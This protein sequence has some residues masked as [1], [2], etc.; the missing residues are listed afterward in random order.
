MSK[1]IFSFL[2]CTLTVFSMEMGGFVNRELAAISFTDSLILASITI[3]KEVAEGT[4]GP[5]EGE[6]TGTATINFLY[7]YDS[8]KNVIS[9]AGQGQKQIFRLDDQNRITRIE[10]GNLRTTKISYGVNEMVIQVFPND[11]ALSTHTYEWKYIYNDDQTIDKAIFTPT[12][13]E[14]NG[15]IEWAKNYADTITYSYDSNGKRVGARRVFWDTNLFHTVP[16]KRSTDSVTYSYDSLYAG[17]DSVLG[18]KTV[19]MLSEFG[20]TWEPMK[21][22]TQWVYL[23]NDKGQIIQNTETR[24]DGAN[25]EWDKLYFFV[26]D[27]KYDN[28]LLMSKEKW[29]FYGDGTDSILN[30]SEVYT[31]GINTIKYGDIKVANSISKASLK[32]HVRMTING[33]NLMVADNIQFDRLEIFSLSGRLIKSVRNSNTINVDGINKKQQLFIKGIKNNR[34]V[35]LSKLLFK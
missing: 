28:S 13:W 32:K 27:Y 35:F 21:G 5:I 3:D 10:V 2:M 1:L 23:Y 14:Y 4:Q 11:S 22:D 6:D 30:R 9:L 26:V 33:N 34:S 29:L 16:W 15:P 18:R 20:N 24:W 17:T 25:K 7:S 19:T 31:Y 12:D 8:V